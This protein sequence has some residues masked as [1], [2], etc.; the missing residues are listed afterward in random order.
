MILP[1]HEE[2]LHSSVTCMVWDGVSSFLR[3]EQ[4]LLQAEPHHT[5]STSCSLTMQQAPVI[6]QVQAGARQ[7][8]A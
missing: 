3:S 7:V 6:S 8:S 5:M 2:G 4:G 1:V